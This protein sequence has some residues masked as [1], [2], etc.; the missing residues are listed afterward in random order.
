MKL[1][2]KYSAGFWYVDF[3]WMWTFMC[4]ITTFMY[5]FYVGPAWLYIVAECKAIAA[6]KSV[7]NY[8]PISIGQRFIQLTLYRSV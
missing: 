7:Q 3:L 6:L 1:R 4:I 2:L 5:E 8:R